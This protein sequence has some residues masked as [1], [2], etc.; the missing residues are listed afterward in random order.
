M[1]EIFIRA[2]PQSYQGQSRSLR[3]HGVATSIRLESLFWEVLETLARRDGMSVG[4][5]ITRLHDELVAYRG[6]AANFTS[7]LRVCCL[8][9]LMLQG[10]GRIPADPRIPI[11]SLDARSVLEG[12]PP[13]WAEEAHAGSRV[14]A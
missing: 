7:F 4:Q 5:L 11:G 6:E 1:C 13:S 8:R 12:L 10:E 3:L 9:Y 14:A 2:T